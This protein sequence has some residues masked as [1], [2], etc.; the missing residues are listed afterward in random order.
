ML[1]RRL[2]KFANRSRFERD[3]LRTLPER[4]RDA[5]RW[6]YDHD[7]TREER[8]LSQKIESFRKRIA[9]VAGAKAIDSLPS[10]HSGTFSLDERGRT[11]GAALASAPV[12]AH[13]RTG[14]SPRDGI[15]LRRL[16]TALRSRNILELG[17]NT[18]FSGCYFVTAETRPHLVTIEGSAKLCEIGRKNIG[19]FSTN[20]TVKHCLFDEAIDQL[21]ES[22]E[23]FDC[24]FIDGQHER[25]ATL[26][27][28]ARVQ[29]LLEPNAVIVFDDVYWSDDMNQAWKEICRSPDYRLTVDFGW[30]GV[31][32]I[33]GDARDKQHFDLCDFIGRPTIARPGW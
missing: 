15:L 13:A 30:K 17:T 32:E 6:E 16:V 10:P 11:S 1:E 8:R 18:G 3:F 5:A 29:P 25:Q 14:I 28:A 7:Y 26:H 4:Y 24:V 20:F 19:R 22:G 33:G 2:L 12:D 9:S 31:A 23:R 27:Y 21:R